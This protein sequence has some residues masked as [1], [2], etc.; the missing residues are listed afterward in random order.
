MVLA[1]V[2]GLIL[3]F[4]ANDNN[5]EWAGVSHAD[6][7]DRTPNCPV[8]GQS[9]QLRFQTYRFDITSARVRVDNAGAI[10][11][12]DAVYL[13]DKGPYAVWTA[14]IPAHASTTLNYWIELTDGSDTDYLSESGTFEDP[15]TDGGFKIDYTTYRHAPL[16]ATPVTG[17]VVFKVWTSASRTQ[18]YVRGQ[19]NNW[20]L[21]DPMVR[22]GE[23]WVRRVN[24]A[25][26]GQMYKYFFNPGA[27]WNSDPRARRLNP[28]DNYNSFIINTNSYNW[29]DENWNPPAF[30]DLVLYELHVGTF[31]GRNDPVASGSNPGTYRDVAAHVDHLVELGVNVVH[32]MPVNEFP[33]DWSAGYNPIT[34]FGLESRLGTP[35]DFKFMVDTLHNNGIAVIMDIVWNHFSGSD[36]FLWNFDGTQI[37]FDTP[38]VETPWGSQ[39]DFDNPQVRSYFLDS[40]K[41]WLEEYHLDGFRM[42]A[43][44]FMNIPPQEAAG[45]S[46]MQALN[47]MMDN[48]YIDHINIAEQLPND[49]WVTRPV[50]LGGAGFDTQWHDAFTDNLR[51]EIF[52]ASFGDPEMFK[53][54]NIINASGQ[55]LNNLFVMN[56]LE[57]HDEAW[58]S[59]G[60]QR[61][62]RTIDNTA[63]HDSE[64]AK[65]RMKLGNGVVMTSPGIPAL[66]Q[67]TEWL[68]DT[69][70]GSGTPS[71]GDRIDWSKKN[72]YREIFDYYSDLIAIRNTNSGLNGNAGRAIIQINEGGNVIAWH[73]FDLNGN[74]L[75]M[76]ANFGNNTYNNYQLGVPAAGDWYTLLNS[77][78]AGYDGSGLGPIGLLT[79]TFG[80][81]DG[82]GQSVRFTLPAMGFIIL[83]HNDDP[84]GFLD[85]DGDDILDVSDNCVDVANPNQ[86]DSDNDGIG[87]ACEAGLVG[88]MNCDG[89]VTVGDIGGFV[90]ALTDP[91]GYAAAFPNCD[92]FNAD[93]NNDGFVTVG[94][95]GGFVTLLT[96]G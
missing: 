39:A 46:L 81:Y 30:E 19:F 28:G 67:G 69:N 15:P 62:V 47:G 76:I 7:Y 21:T 16:G 10:S 37:Y 54:A 82:Q 6:H 59:S 31:S 85:V 71:G 3:F 91:T 55:Y 84:D 96:G 17:G 26:P 13:R 94:D 35:D 33:W 61:A 51:Q 65:G 14:T 63:P 93:V 36:N 5:I 40:A 66:L 78:A 58:T 70:F 44:D 1:P 4:A 56:Y 95:I 72:T 52:D 24:G 79:A 25:V 87:D 12:V 8:D 2:F 38:T 34:M 80:P 90:L 89:F 88:D 20:G 32:I 53:I 11:F 41:M 45:W 43:T 27:V 77:Q 23:V 92:I 29:T 50:S 75:M 57:L 18:A 48:R 86:A 60:G 64:F 68:E 73:R 74:R 22:V 49:P 83:R 9:F 42:D